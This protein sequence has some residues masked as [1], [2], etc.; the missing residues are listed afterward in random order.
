V[1]PLVV[2]LPVLTGGVT[3]AH[4]YEIFEVAAQ[5]RDDEGLLQ[6]AQL[7]A[8]QN[9]AP[10]QLQQLLLLL[11][12]MLHAA[13]SDHNT[14]ADVSASSIEVFLAML[15]VKPAQQLDSDMI[16][17]LLEA[18][19][20]VAQ[21]APTSATGVKLSSVWVALCQL[22]QALELEHTSILSL[23]EISLSRHAVRFGDS[24]TAALC[25][26]L[27]QKSTHAGWEG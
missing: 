17:S 22:P 18:S 20:R 13:L 2:A 6:Y 25:S 4:V 11:L 19:F 1:Q 23:L 5:Q 7:P 15:Q 16:R 3:F 10:A 9:A 12:A 21:Q 26:L 8:V 24:G 14:D 27:D